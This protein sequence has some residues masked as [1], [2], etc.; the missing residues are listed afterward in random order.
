LLENIQGMDREAV[1]MV[2]SLESYMAKYA[3][4]E[5]DGPDLSKHMIEF[6]DWQLD[7]PFPEGDLTILCCPEDRTCE[8]P[9]CQAGRRCC[10]KCKLPLCRECSSY[11]KK[12]T[13]SVPPAALANDMMVFYEPAELYT[14]QVTTMELLCASVCLTS[15]I[16]FTL[17]AKYR[18]ENPLDEQVHM[19]RHR[20]GARGN[21]TSFP[22]PWQQLLQ[23][24]EQNA[25]TA[26]DLPR[27][28]IELSDYVSVVLKTNEESSPDSLARFVH[29]ARV[30]RSIV[31]SLIRNAK[32]RGHRAYKLVDM[33]AVERKARHLPEDGVP[34]EIVALLPHDD[35]LDQ[36]LVQKAADPAR[37]RG[38]VEE[39]AERMN[40]SQPNAVVDEKS[41]ND[42]SDINAQ[43]IAALRHLTTKLR[44]G[45]SDDPDT[46]SESAPKARRISITTGS[47]M[48]DQFTPWYFGVAFAFLFK[49][50][51]GMPD[52][53]AFLEKERYR[54]S[55]DAPRIEISEWEH[56]RASLICVIVWLY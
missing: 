15:M 55:E 1:E 45:R 33:D 23:Q 54:R 42:A 30:R 46:V 37:G 10:P 26:P 52:G 44:P 47:Q 8:V 32:D 3:C 6:D 19:A 17:E 21:A 4:C 49:L 43:R 25:T 14:H 27:V 16:C 40:D 41:S 34:P 56:N 53:P 35:S 24:L 50:C 36:V 9:D 18:R 13:P 22:L 7:V 51:T 48:V 38:S 2:L 12:K 29:Q 39:V 28:G 31:V 5:P 11:L 20:M